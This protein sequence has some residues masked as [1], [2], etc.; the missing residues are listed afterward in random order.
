MAKNRAL[1]W[2]HKKLLNGE[3]PDKLKAC[4]GSFSNKKKDVFMK[5]KNLTSKA[6]DKRYSFLHDVYILLDNNKF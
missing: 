1:N 3:S 5:E 6:Y 4:V 2:I